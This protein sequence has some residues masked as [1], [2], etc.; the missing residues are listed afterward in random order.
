MAKSI[1]SRTAILAVLASIPGWAQSTPAPVGQEAQKAVL[2]SIDQSLDAVESQARRSLFGGGSKPVSFAGEALMRFIG[3]SFDEYPSWMSKDRTETKNSLASVRMSMVAAPQ[4]NLRLWSKLAFNHTFMGNN[5]PSD[6]AFGGSYRQTPQTGY[7]DPHSNNLFEDMAAGL[8]AKTGDVTTH[9]RIG[10]VLWTEASPLTLWKGQ[11]RMFGWDYVP[12]ELEQSSA[13]YWEYATIKGEKTGRA[14]WNKKPFQGINLESIEMPWNLYYT[15][16][17]G[18]FEG[19]QKFQ[20]YYINTSNTNGLQ[21]TGEAAGGRSFASKGLG[22]GDGYR[23][24]TTF[25]VAKAELPGAITLGANFMNFKADN[26]YAKQWLWGANWGGLSAPDAYP[27]KATYRD[28]GTKMAKTSANLDT[29]VADTVLKYKSNYFI[30]HTV[31]SMDARRTLPGGLQFHVDLAMSQTDTAYFKVNDS[32]KG[33]YR[34]YRSGFDSTY[35]A[36]TPYLQVLGHKMSAI[37]PAIYGNVN[38]PTKYAQFD[39]SGIWAP[40][41]FYSGTSFVMPLDAFFPFESNLLGAGKFAGTDG[42]TPYASNMTGANLIT[43]IPVS[44]GHMR[45]STGF[46]KQLENGRDLIYIPWRL[47]GTAFKYSQNASTTQY[48]GAGLEDDYMRGNPADANA[49]TDAKTPSLYR[50]VRRMG[51]DF[52][53]LPNPDAKT[54]AAG[55][56]RRNAYAPSSGEAGGIR[57]DFMAT[58]E[59]FGMYRMRRLTAVEKASTDS[60]MIKS[61]LAEYKSDSMDIVNM[62]ISG[63]LPQSTKNTQNLSLDVSYDVARLWGGKKALFLGFYGSLNSVTKNGTPIPALGD[64]ENTA[65][66]GSLLRFEPVAQLAQGFYLIGLVGMETW[67]SPYGVALID[68]ATGY[69]PLDTRFTDP[70]YWVA[71]PID[72]TDMMFGIGFDWD[73]A[74]RVGLH[75]R[76]QRFSHEDKGISAFATKAAGH[77]DYKAWLL[78]AETKMWF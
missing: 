52:Y 33:N 56:L 9:A 32:G 5:S 78:H 49:G 47:N 6:A 66:R 10:G 8:M 60:G 65:V 18:S 50:Q 14:A 40:K 44:G 34:Q 73:M 15:L 30:S 7:Y 2:D 25:R 37:T 67:K 28:I 24:A 62:G 64:D 63:M 54:W 48:D 21:Y 71:A 12:Y 68:T 55:T 77:N 53:T 45:L 42:G 11:N 17:Y 59:N 22:V 76:L 41:D 20:P 35:V 27:I 13:Q 26:D 16:T 70:K 46:H 19:F 58:F 4:R 57:G 39:L 23:K 36:N 51:D 61:R 38:Y 43:K 69:Q 29:I 3:T 75:M 74:S 1:S 31:G 72:Y